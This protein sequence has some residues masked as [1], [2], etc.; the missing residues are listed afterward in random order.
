MGHDLRQLSVP[1]ELFLRAP[2]ADGDE[3]VAELDL[4]ETPDAALHAAARLAVVGGVRPLPRLDREQ[5]PLGRGHQV[6]AN[7]LRR[8][9]DAFDGVLGRR[10][11]P[12]DPL[13]W[14]GHLDSPVEDGIRLPVDPAGRPAGDPVF[15]FRRLLRDLG[16]DPELARLGQCDDEVVRRRGTLCASLPRAA[17]VRRPRR[18]DR[19]GTPAVAGR[20][21]PGRRS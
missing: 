19:P 18:C 14:I 3:G 4:F 9:I 12:D 8:E 1:L 20:I 10:Q 16:A 2:V 13:A 15:Q 11:R 17:C 21:A 6:A 5:P 7:S